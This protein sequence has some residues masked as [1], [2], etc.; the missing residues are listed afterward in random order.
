M[1]DSR[2]MRYSW[3]RRESARLPSSRVWLFVSSLARYQSP[4]RAGDVSCS[5]AMSTVGLTSD[6]SVVVSIDLA[7]LLAGSAVRGSFEDKMKN[8]IQDIEDEKGNVIAFIG[9]SPPCAP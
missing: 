7:S 6:D 3:V 5:T 8:L 2:T 9:E 1:S 4:S